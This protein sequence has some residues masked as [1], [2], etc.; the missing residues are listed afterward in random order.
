MEIQEQKYSADLPVL[1]V[2]SRGSQVKTGHLGLNE[3][4]YLAVEGTLEYGLTLGCA[5]SDPSQVT[6]TLRLL[7]AHYSPPPG[8][9][10]RVLELVNRVNRRL[11][12]RL[13]GETPGD[14]PRAP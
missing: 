5:D 12:E 11:A 1:L 10:P 8:C 2:D 3:W 6:V 4:G 9:S 7:T 13:L 14:V